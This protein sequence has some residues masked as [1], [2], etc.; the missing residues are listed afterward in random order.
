MN[1]I[2]WKS[3]NDQE[4]VCL[5]ADLLRAL[6]FVNINIQG[7]GPDGGLDLIATELVP[8][9]IHGSHPFTWG[10]QCKFSKTGTQKSVND[11]E[12]RDIEGILRSDRYSAHNLRGYMLITNRKIVQ[13][14]VERLQGINRN[15]SFR[16]AHIDGIQLSHRLQEY[17]KIIEKYFTIEKYSKKV[18]EAI[19]DFRPPIIINDLDP[20]SRFIVNV[21]LI[22]PDK[23]KD[24]VTVKA[25]IDTGATISVM[26][27]PIL[28]KLGLEYTY[29]N[30]SRVTGGTMPEKCFWCDIRI[31]ALEFNGVGLLALDIPYGLIGQDILKHYTLLLDGPNGVVKW[32]A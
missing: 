8:F 17:P 30:V 14:I 11:Q 26:P 27:K 3:I 1:T 28:E 7:V 5:T 2:E 32:W 19:Q 12:I 23:R 6:G 29:V 10:I 20:G 25:L 24:I 16:T 18:K 21:G 15:S 4:F 22:S 9:A 31:E 13:N